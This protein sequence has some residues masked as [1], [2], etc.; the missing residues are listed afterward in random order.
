MLD[1]T[2]GAAWD[3]YCEKAQPVGAAWRCFHAE[4]WPPV[5]TLGA[6]PMLFL[7]Y[8]YDMA[9]VCAIRNPYTA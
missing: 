4:H 8:L 6:V 5:T 3:P 9:N 1:G 2:F 7:E